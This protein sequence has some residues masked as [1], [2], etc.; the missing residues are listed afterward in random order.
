MLVERVE[1][2]ISW[3]DFK[4]GYSFFIPCLDRQSAKLEIQRVAKRLKLQ[5]LCKG[6]IEGGVK[7]LRVWRL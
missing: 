4:K 1:Y 5:I 2:I 3:K 6:V 7:G